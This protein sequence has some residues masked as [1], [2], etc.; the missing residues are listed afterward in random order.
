MDEAAPMLNLAARLALRAAGKVEPNPLVGC[1]LTQ[2]GRV[3]GMGHHRVFGG[4]HAEADALADAARRNEPTRGATAFVTLEPC[5]AQGRQPPCTQALIA[6]GIA[7]VVYACADP[8]P[9]KA[10]GA[11]AL[12]AAGIETILSNASPLATSLAAPFLKR[13]TT[14]M[15]WVIAKWAQTMD[16]RVATRTGDSK[17]ISGEWARRRVHLLRARVDAVLTGMGTVL[18]DD[19]M[20]TARL[21]YTPRRMASRVV[22][23]TDMRLPLDS[24]LATTARD[25][26]TILAVERS[27]ACTT[28]TAQRRAAMDQLGVTIIPIADQGHGHGLNLT[29]LLAT[30]HKDHH[31]STLLIEAGP[32]LMGSMFEEDLIDEAVV[33]IAPLMLGDE[34]AKSVAVGR[35]ADK[36][37]N[38]RRFELARVKQL[39]PD[40]E[41]V[42]R[43]AR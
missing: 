38:A 34:Q 5:N 36:L 8:N 24:K 18:S 17:W 11:A 26:P 10:G 28:Y 12:R 29:E 21:P 30:L 22:V 2:R 23:D 31:V 9:A 16:G 40:I 35:S 33:Y 25:V 4:P 14:G 20:L 39:G 15:P 32:G 42:Y 19:P 3:I 7:R 1:V 6:A 43:R 41:A 27:M 37:S 13:V